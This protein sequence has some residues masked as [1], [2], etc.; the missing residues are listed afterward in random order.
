MNETV[1]RMERGDN[2]GNYKHQTA[3]K[4]W[5]TGCEGWG[6]REVKGD[7]QCPSSGDWMDGKTARRRGK[8]GLLGVRLSLHLPPQHT[9]THTNTHNAPLSH[10][11]TH[12]HNAPLSHTMHLSL[13]HSHTHNAPLS[14]SYTHT[15]PFL[16]CKFQVYSIVI[17]QLCA[18]HSD[19]HQS[20]VTS[21]HL[22][23]HPTQTI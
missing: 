12:T 23:V 8:W 2:L 1:L 13:S 21:H 5:R 10:T 19:H 9:H 14:L 18:L 3:R 11:Q 4:W 22:T 20:L 16:L 15:H 17:W 7:W 6:A